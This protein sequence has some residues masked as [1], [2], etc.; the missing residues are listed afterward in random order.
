MLAYWLCVEVEVSP[1]I[2]LMLLLH[3]TDSHMNN[4]PF[5]II[6]SFLEVD[7]HLESISNDDV[8]LPGQSCREENN[9]R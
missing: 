3:L 9:S 1:N 8:Q 4:Q 7:S 2:A 5:G 6:Y